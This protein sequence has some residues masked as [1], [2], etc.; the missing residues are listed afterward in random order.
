MLGLGLSGYS[1]I[2]FLGFS[3]HLS[4]LLSNVLFA[5]SLALGSLVLLSFFI[6]RLLKFFLR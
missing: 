5:L 3:G 2:L 4:G 1:A 6:T